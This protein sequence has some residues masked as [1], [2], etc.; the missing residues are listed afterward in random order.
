MDDTRH[1]SLSL[2]SLPAV[3]AK[4]GVDVGPGSDIFQRL[5]KD[6]GPTDDI[7]IFNNQILC[8]V[9]IRPQKTA[10]GLYLTSQT[11]DEDRH[12]SK[13]GLIVKMGPKAFADTSGEW[14]EGNTFSKGDW[15]VFR[16][17]DGWAVTINPATKVL[18]R[19]IDD[20][21]VRAR[22]RHPDQVW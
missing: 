16:P 17:S 22:V 2:P 18:C 19:V 4:S 9:Y 13:V 20:V 10:S 8:A 14:F 21:N 1:P 12:Q 7:E 15:V 3:E 6:L 11:T 5:L